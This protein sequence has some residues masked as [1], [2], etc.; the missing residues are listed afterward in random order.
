MKMKQEDRQ[1][2]RAFYQTLAAQSFTD[3]Q[4]ALYWAL[5]KGKE[6]RVNWIRSYGGTVGVPA[7][8]LAILASD[9]EITKADLAVIAATAVASKTGTGLSGFVDKVISII[10]APIR[11]LFGG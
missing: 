3:A 11:W 4:E 6:A 7:P 2:L 5:V 1:A 10:T 8:I 9:V